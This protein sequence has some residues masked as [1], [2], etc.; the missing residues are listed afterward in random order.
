MVSESV[1]RIEPRRRP[2]QTDDVVIDELKRKESVMAASNER[3]LHPTINST[4]LERKSERELVITRTFDASPRLVFQ[5]WTTPEMFKQWWVPKSCGA[6]LLSCEQDVHVGGSYRLEFAHPEAATP[7]AF[8]GKYLEV[9]PNARL[10]WSNEESDDGAVTTVT[11]EEKDGHTLLVM[12]ER[13]PS[14]QALDVAIEGSAEAMPETFDQ[15][16]RFLA[17]HGEGVR[18]T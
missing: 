5:A 11:F 2:R 17:A 4:T 3:E 16:D 7:M 8:F 18:R 12:H 10:V 9:Q 1:K 14:Q 13:Y 15:L 6:T